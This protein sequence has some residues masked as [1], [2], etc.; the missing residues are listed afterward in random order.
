MDAARLIDPDSLSDFCHRWKISRLE[1]FG[2][3]ARGEERPDSDLDLLVTFEPDAR[4]TLL[5]QVAMED[6][7]AVRVGR[8]V[9]MVTRRAVESS[10]NPLRRRMILDE[11]EPF[12]AA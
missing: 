8:R 12:Y 9:E 4:W 5:D 6:E 7:L 2:S 10:R 1:V 11:A 3:V